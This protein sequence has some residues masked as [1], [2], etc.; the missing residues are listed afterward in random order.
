M[1]ELSPE[2]K[3]LLHRLH[4]ILLSAVPEDRFSCDGTIRDARMNL[5]IGED[6]KW[7]VFFREGALV[8]DVTT[9][10]SLFEAGLQLIQ[11]VAVSPESQADM[12]RAFRETYKP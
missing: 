5:D 11:N 3:S 4:E 10:D 9:H 6:G 2:E 8:E 12:Q 7:Y 1:K